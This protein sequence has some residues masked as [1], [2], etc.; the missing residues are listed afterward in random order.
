VRQEQRLGGL[1]ALSRKTGLRQKIGQDQSH[2]AWLAAFS[3][4]D[5]DAKLKRNHGRLDRSRQAAPQI[6]ETLRDRIL[7]LALKPNTVLSRAE[8]QSEF[9]I[10]QTPVRDALMKLEQEGLVEV[11]PQHATVVARIDIDAARQAH[12]LRVAIEL[13]AV[14]RVSQKPEAAFIAR[15]RAAIEEQRKMTSRGDYPGFVAADH[16]M[17]QLFCQE[18]GVPDLWQ[19]IRRQCGHIDRLRLL[20]LPLP[21]KIE[22]VIR[23]HEAIIDAIEKRN[24][25]G[26]AAALRKHLSGTLSIIDQIRERHPDYFIA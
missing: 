7:T 6:F 23:D 9:G 14:R 11:Y 2:A 5:M 1:L 26:A 19:I 24:P 12:F 15:L 4:S 17:H 10:S 8:L 16:A 20:N 13:E 18:A 3:G 22:A 21:G 25:D